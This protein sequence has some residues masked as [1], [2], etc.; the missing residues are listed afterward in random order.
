M[1][2]ASF[3]IQDGMPCSV[4]TFGTPRSA[5][6]LPLF[7]LPAGGDV[8]QLMEVQH[9]RLDRAVAEGL[10]PS[11]VLAAF[12]TPDWYGALSPW[13]SPALRGEPAFSGNARSTLDW[14]LESLIPGVE[15]RLPCVRGGP[16]GVLGY[17][18][19]G[20]FALWAI[21]Q[22]DAFA[23]CGSCSGALWYDGFA[24]YVASHA[25]LG[26][27]SVYL[28]L[29][30][31]EEKAHNPRFA[32]VGEATRRIAAQIASSPMV[33]DSTMVWHPGGHFHLIG[34]RLAAAQLWMAQHAKQ[35]A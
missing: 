1:Q 12:E 31:K 22:T 11:F 3:F 5:G 8:R 9:M 21:Y 34:Q 4:H 20:M 24:G 28:S 7:V 17:S 16:R 25:P 26:A 32:Q 13:P 18:M 10:A 14:V 29:G 6:R 2:P 27:C 35:G 30:I 23:L 19:A 33:Q 15:E